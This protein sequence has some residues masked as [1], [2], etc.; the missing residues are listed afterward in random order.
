MFQGQFDMPLEEFIRAPPERNLRTHDFQLRHR[1]FPRA[2]RGAAFTVRLPWRWNKISLE[3]VTAITLD[4]FK[5]MLDDRWASLFRD[6][7]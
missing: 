1:R 4:T 2:R 3:A 5:S 6:V 7:L